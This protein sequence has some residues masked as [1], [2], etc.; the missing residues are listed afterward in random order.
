MQE[1]F[2]KNTLDKKRPL[3]AVRKSSNK[4]AL[5]DVED[6]IEKTKECS[7]PLRRLAYVDSTDSETDF[8]DGYDV[9]LTAGE[10]DQKYLK[11]LSERDR[12]LELFR[13]GENRVIQKLHWDIERKIKKRFK[14]K[15]PAELPDNSKNTISAVKLNDSHTSS[16]TFAVPTVNVFPAIP[17]K[18]SKQGRPC[19]EEISSDHSEELASKRHRIKVSEPRRHSAMEE[20]KAHHIRKQQRSEF[21][22][23]NFDSITL[24]F[25]SFYIPQR[26][27]CSWSWRS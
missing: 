5:F 4:K 12:E 15:S 18:F 1:A 7:R 23:F 22:P 2:D 8:S 25:L 21:G 13:R 17:K 19:E 20:L 27:S 11:S 26:S 24:S 16:K 3:I 10:A 6:S 14:G 9:N